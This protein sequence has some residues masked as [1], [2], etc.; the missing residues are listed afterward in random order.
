MDGWVG[1][2]TQLIAPCFSEIVYVSFPWENKVPWALWAC[3]LCT[4]DLQ[5]SHTMN[6]ASSGT[7]L[8][9][10][11]HQISSSF[12]SYLYINMEKC[13]SAWI[14]KLCV[15]PIPSWLGFLAHLPSFSYLEKQS[16]FHLHD[17]P[18]VSP[19]VHY[20][21]SVDGSWSSVSGKVMQVNL[22]LCKIDENWIIG[23]LF[24]VCMHWC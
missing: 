22:Q 11:W 9:L 3:F 14:V 15:V 24:P 4:R 1:L 17:V 20:P 23:K 12:H 2:H 6:M 8:W 10:V 7:K 13:P 21:A 19:A 16:T 18:P 5:G